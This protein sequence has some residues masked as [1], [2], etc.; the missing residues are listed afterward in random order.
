ML[1][2]GK[3]ILYAAIAGLLV[4]MGAIVYYA[5]LDNPELEKLEIKLSNVELLDVNSIE[6][7]AK[8]ELIF[9]VKNPSEKTFTVANISYELYANNKLIGTGQ[10]STEDVA[11]PGRAAF[12]PNSEIPLKNIFNLILSDVNAQEYQSIVNGEPVKYSVEGIITAETAWSL[13]EKE[14]QSN[15]E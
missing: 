2:Q 15:M 1:L 13:V 7:Q 4:I 6:N 11:M 9:L 8:L 14:F 12:Y 10:Y 5:S 3:M